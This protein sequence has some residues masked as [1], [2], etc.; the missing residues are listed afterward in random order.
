MVDPRCARL[1][2]L[3]GAQAPAA[4]TSFPS[5]GSPPRAGWAPSLPSALRDS[6]APGG[7]RR[8]ARTW[9]RRP[10]RTCARPGLPPPALHR[11][12]CSG[13]SRAGPA[14]G[15]KATATALRAG[16]FIPLWCEKLHHFGG[17]VWDN[18]GACFSR[19]PQPLGE[20]GVLFTSF[21][22]SMCASNFV[23]ATDP[24]AQHRKVDM[25]GCRHPG[26]W[27]SLVS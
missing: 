23:S 27:A 21:T 11:R 15:V 22:R 10:G 26:V 9:T 12:N 17:L 20:A 14:S 3:P 1:R 18:F 7:G 25:E 19:P 8:S 6:P 4:P 24:D 2:L 13:A 5:L 16:S